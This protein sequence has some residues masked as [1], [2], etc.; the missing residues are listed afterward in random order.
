MLFGPDPEVIGHAVELSAM[1]FLID[2]IV[3]TEE[4]CFAADRRE[5]MGSGDSS[6]SWAS[7]GR[8]TILDEFKRSFEE[9]FE[10]P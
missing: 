3:Q 4:D 5:R 8:W 6:L 1:C 7:F 2:S 9:L 10:E